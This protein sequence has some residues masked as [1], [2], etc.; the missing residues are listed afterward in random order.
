MT[1]KPPFSGA[2]FAIKRKNLSK[3]VDRQKTLCYYGAADVAFVLQAPFCCIFV[4]HRFQNRKYFD[5]NGEHFSAQQKPLKLPSFLEKALKRPKPS[6]Q[7]PFQKWKDIGGLE[8]N[9]SRGN[10]RKIA[11]FTGLRGRSLLHFG[12]RSF[13]RCYLPLYSYLSCARE[14]SAN[15]VRKAL[16]QR[17]SRR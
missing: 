3:R 7:G 12:A 10:W 5:R 8:G 17:P 16:Y 15:T 11:H 14:R 1:K 9:R 13:Q 6:I 4:A 2:A